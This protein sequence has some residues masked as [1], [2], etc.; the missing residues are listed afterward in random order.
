MESIDTGRDKLVALAV[1]AHPDDIEFLL[2]GTLL[3]LRAAGAET[4][5]WNLSCGSCGTADLPRDEIIRIRAGE[6]A[7]SAAIAGA[8]LHPPVADDLAI[9]YE[10]ATLARVGS[11]IRGVKP[12]IILTQPPHDYMEDHQNT[13]R[14]VVTAAFGRCMPNFAVDP[15]RDAWH[16]P[17]AIYH[18][19]PH[20]LRDG[21]RR[22]QRPGVYVDC[23]PVMETKRAMLSEHRS[24]K[25]WLD[26][27]Q[28][29]GSYIAEM[30]G[31]CR[32]LGSMSHRYEFA[33][34]WVRHL[35]LGFG[36]ADYDPLSVAL[37]AACWT[38]PDF[39]AQLDW[40]GP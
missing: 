10:P 14:L 39:E 4:H 15:P 38:D 12:D 8:T 19:M 16:G 34:G 18:S 24:Q 32:T 6:A 30:E 22:L 3:Q 11:V 1:A 20:G 40:F 35:H 25:E 27:S 17:T 36:P 21:L 28:G 7:R 5:M 9:F 37:G 29:M 33:E 2:A 13:C 23:G 26:R 31:L